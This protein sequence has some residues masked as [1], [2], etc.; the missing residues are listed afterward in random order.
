M[1]KTLLALTLAV[2]LTSFAGSGKA[3]N[4]S[5]SLDSSLFGYLN[6]YEPQITGVFGGNA[7]VPTSAINAMVYMQNVAPDIFGI[8]L[9]GSSYNDWISANLDLGANYL[10]TDPV[11]GTLATWRQSG[12]QYYFNNKIGPNIISVFD[13]Q[14]TE[15]R[16]SSGGVIVANTYSNFPSFS[17]IKQALADNNPIIIGF[18]QAQLGHEAVVTGITWDEIN[19]TGMLSIIDPLNPSALNSS[20]GPAMVTQ[21]SISL[22]STNITTLYE[23]NGAN[24]QLVTSFV[25][26]LQIN[27]SAYV[28]S[29]PFET[30]N[31]SNFS[32]Y[33]TG[34]N[35]FALTSGNSFGTSSGSIPEPSTYALFGLGA[36]V[37]LM[38]LR[39][40]KTV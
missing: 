5:V 19:N 21:A 38:V 28:G 35:I 15:T 8:N 18:S 22:V 16:T 10:M 1:K 29:N 12:L 24:V 6:Q 40:K 30:N 13:Y 23:T 36:I 34:A 3:Q 31:Y 9:A 4:I 27:Y 26:A 39:R 7:C 33:I 37:M 20:S 32:G 17:T 11:G 25:D 14:I 2:G